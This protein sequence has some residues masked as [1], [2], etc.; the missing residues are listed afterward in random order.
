M[1]KSGLTEIFIRTNIVER[2]SK[3]D[4]RLEEQREKTE[5]AGEFME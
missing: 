1:T 5:L 4:I 3:S 2:T